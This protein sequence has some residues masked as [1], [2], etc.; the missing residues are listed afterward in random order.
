V[1][2]IIGLLQSSSAVDDNGNY[3]WLDQRLSGWAVNYGDILVTESIR[4]KIVNTGIIYTN[5]GGHFLIPP[6]VVLM[7]GSTYLHNSFDF[8]SACLTLESINC[9]IICYGLGAQNTTRDLSFLDENKW[10]QRF[11]SI[12]SE[13]S[14]TISVRGYFTADIL[15]RYGVSNIRVTGCPSICF[16]DKVS[17]INNPIKLSNNYRIGL[18]THLGLHDDI[19]C[20]N[21]D[22][23]KKLHVQLF[24]FLEPYN[25]NILEQGNLL[26]ILASDRDIE[27]EE[28]L[29]AGKQ[30]IEYLGANDISPEL[31]ISKYVRIKNLNEWLS[32]V[33]DCDLLIGFRFH[34][35][36]AGLMQGLPVFMYTYDSRMEEFSEF[37][38]IPSAPVENG[39]QDPFQSILNYDWDICND[40][41]IA[42]ISECELFDNENNLKTYL[43][44]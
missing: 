7:R 32:K 29:F 35:L 5:F 14:I 44:T 9:P 41:I 25:F 27:Y 39:L 13:K 34:G 18:S 4:K 10:A 23:T 42:G 1:K 3:K 20:R 11:M 24:K 21:V 15:K 31:F 38:K 36:I 12:L 16:P 19:F 30:L 17:K 8:E 6:D 33:R 2:K 28:R 37:Y 26:E 22:L 43:D 40:A